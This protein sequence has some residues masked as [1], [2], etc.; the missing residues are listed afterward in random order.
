MPSTL[1]LPLINPGKLNVSLFQ[2]DARTNAR[3]HRVVRM[4]QSRIGH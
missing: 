3:I 1:L 4:Q 2:Q